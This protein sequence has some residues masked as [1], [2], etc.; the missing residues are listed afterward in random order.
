MQNVELFFFGRQS[1]L[2]CIFSIFRTTKIFATRVIIHAEFSS[3]DM[4][5]HQLQGAT[6]T[7]AFAPGPH[8]RLRPCMQIP[9]RFAL[10]ALATCRHPIGYSLAPT[11][12]IK[13]RPF[14]KCQLTK[15]YYMRFR[16]PKIAEGTSTAKKLRQWRSDFNKRHIV[17]RL[18]PDR[19]PIA[20]VRVKQTPLQ[21]INS[22]K[23]V[24]SLLKTFE[25]VHRAIVAAEVVVVDRLHVLLICSRS[26]LIERQ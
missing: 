7:R 22:H 6:T 18:E 15:L 13:L 26:R 23:C 12:K 1:Y 24:T 3:W 20:K 16:K 5:S 8:W 17:F 19:Y 10:H 4:Y 25:P 11:G 2:L 14:P 21:G 9:Y